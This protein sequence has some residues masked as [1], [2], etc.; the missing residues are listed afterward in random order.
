ML[1]RSRV[2]V[3]AHGNSLRALIKYF[4][5][6]SDA[7]IVNE[8]VPTG[9]PLVYELDD[10]LQAIRR[11]YLGDAEAVAKAMHSVASQGKAK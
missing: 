2:L 3:S 1:F 8:N 5:K 10:S 7:A 6:M 9:M 4:D 11:Y